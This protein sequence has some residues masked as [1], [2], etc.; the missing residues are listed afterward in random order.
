MSLS[1][2]ARRACCLTLFLTCAAAWADEAAIL[3]NLHEFF[4]TTNPVNREQLSKRI[5]A[6]PDYDRSRVS[7]WLHAAGLFEPLEPG[8]RRIEIPLAEGKSMS[9]A[10]RIPDSYDHARPWPLIYAMHGQGGTGEG[11][12]WMVQSLLGQRVDEFVIAA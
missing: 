9:V 12:I 5:A 1:S 6:D 2:P 7:E 4:N 8:T 10:V 11:I 3:K